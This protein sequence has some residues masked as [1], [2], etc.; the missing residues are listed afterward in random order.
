MLTWLCANWSMA[1]RRVQST[2]R[3]IP[4][5]V[6]DFLAQRQTTFLGKHVPKTNSINANTAE[7]IGVVARKR[8]QM[9]TFR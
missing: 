4:V 5:A 3:L 6:A 9:P 8:F 1:Q 7:C 2:R